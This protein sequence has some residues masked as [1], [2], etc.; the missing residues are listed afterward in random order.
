MNILS[1]FIINK[2]KLLENVKEIN[3]SQ[4]CAMVKADAYGH[5]LEQIVSILKSKVAFFGVANMFEALR[6]RKESSLSKILIVGRCQ[7]FEEAAKNGISLTV[8]NKNDLLELQKF[9]TNSVFEKINIHLK[10]NTGMNRLGIATET[11]LQDCIKIIMHSNKISL[12][13]VFTHFSTLDCDQVFFRKQF[14]KFK[15]M[16]KQIPPLLNPILHIGGG[17]VLSQLTPEEHRKYMVRVGL[18]LYTFPHQ[19]LSI[20]S[21]IIKLHDLKPGAKVGYSNGYVCPKA[22]K[23]AV[24][25]LGYADGVNRKLGQSGKVKVKI[26]GKR[27]S[28]VGN[29]CMDMFFVD[30]SE[31][32]CCIGDKVEVFFNADLWAKFAG[33][34]TYEILTTLDY[35]R[36]KYVVKD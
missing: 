24:I 31:I 4:I 27:A 32:N 6:V 8:E 17:A 16:T 28:M 35:R 15:R 29:V 23:I 9:M 14:A 26:K 12:E 36:M 10:I 20:E 21:E 30:V 1:K 33:T 13:G 22:K 7:D 34:T 3:H 11:E 5:G 2:K 18:I 25:P 19:V